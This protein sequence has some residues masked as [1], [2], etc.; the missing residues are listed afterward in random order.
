[1]LGCLIVGVKKPCW[2]CDLRLQKIRI[3]NPRWPPISTYFAIF[4]HFEQIIHFGITIA[5]VHANLV[6]LLIHVFL[7]FLRDFFAAFISDEY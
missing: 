7:M 5:L 6:L 4:G 2:S 1:M 3:S